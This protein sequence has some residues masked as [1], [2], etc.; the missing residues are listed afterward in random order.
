MLGIGTVAAPLLVMQP[1]LGV[2]IASSKTKAPCRN[3]FKSLV[4]HAVFGI[5]LYLAAAVINT[6]EAVMKNP[7]TWKHVGIFE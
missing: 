4:N 6:V 1:A 5:G 3:S 7:E 2:G